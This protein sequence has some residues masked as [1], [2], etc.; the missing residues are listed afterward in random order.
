MKT[1]IKR[2]LLKYLILKKFNSV[3]AGARAINISFS[4]LSGILSGAVSEL[5]LVEE[6]KIRSRLKMK[7]ET[8]EEV[9]D[10]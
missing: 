3:S 1:Q 7:K 10:S 8:F 2:H 5:T 4:R 9:M 6:K